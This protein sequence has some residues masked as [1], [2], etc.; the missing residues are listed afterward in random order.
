MNEPRIMTLEEVEGA[1]FVHLDLHGEI[2]PDCAVH[3]FKDHPNISF[4]S[5]ENINT[6]ARKSEYGRTWR[7]WTEVPTITQQ[8]AVAWDA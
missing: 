5:P 1:D 2:M 6:Y 4:T 3:V 7:C 8:K